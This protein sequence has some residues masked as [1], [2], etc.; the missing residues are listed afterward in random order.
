M[1]TRMDMRTSCSPGVVVNA[2]CD[3]PCHMPSCASWVASRV[4]PQV[5]C[6]FVVVP[7]LVSSSLNRLL[8]PVTAALPA[9]V[10][11]RLCVE[12]RSRAAECHSRRVAEG[13]AGECARP[14]SL[15]SQQPLFRPGKCLIRFRQPPKPIHPAGP[16]REFLIFD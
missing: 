2:I 3:H 14:W 16:Q 15:L 6:S 8:N 9:A 7:Q 4:M 11:R 12:D 5:L 10:H 1:F 13:G